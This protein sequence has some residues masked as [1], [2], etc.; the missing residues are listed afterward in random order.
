MFFLDEKY[1]INNQMKFEKQTY[2]LILLSIYIGLF[3][4]ESVG[5]SQSIASSKV[6]LG[7]SGNSINTVIFRN[8]A[9]T[10][11]N[12]FQF[13][14]YYN[15]EGY[16]VLAKRSLGTNK[17]LK[18]I[19]QYKG[20][21][22]D[23][24]NSISIAI[25]NAGYLHVSWDQH[26]SPLR[27]AK[28][29]DPLGIELSE[30]L[31]MTGLQESSVTYPEFHNLPNGK[32]LFL[33]RS[34][35]SGNGNLV[36]NLYNPKSKEWK[37]IQND[38]ISGEDARNAYWQTTIDKLGNIHLSWVWR[39]TWDVGTNHDLCYA[40]STDNG[41]TWEKS[42][43]EKYQIPIIKETAEV[44]CYIPQGS[45]LINQTS[46]DT[47]SEGN[48]FIAS[49]WSL[50]E[51]TPQYK[52]VYHKDDNWHLMDTDFHKTAF[53][54]TGG[55]TKRIPLSRPKILVGDQGVYVLFRDEE[56]GNRMTLA[57]TNLNKVNWELSDISNVEV[58]QWEPNYDV[59]QWKTNNEIHVFSQKVS[60]I[61]GEGLDKIDPQPIY[62]VEFRDN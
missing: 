31:E 17:W 29:I 12:E 55:G 59:N 49:Y 19:T 62:I 16:M 21:I 7:W 34:G 46:M 44:A 9:L 40:I 4:G 6:G 18:H 52:V 54:L 42:N 36:M 51:G 30:E 41:L 60:Q 1:A 39:E 47:D 45:N 25:D 23:A 5:F 15:Q 32:L 20:N 13:T 53:S 58:G 14:A 35:E 48:P 37:Q 3:L 38:L 57:K 24:H 33:Y 43:G 26:N 22:Q 27:Y 61:D 2:K 10:S 11:N 50:Q 56:M 8:Q 28:S